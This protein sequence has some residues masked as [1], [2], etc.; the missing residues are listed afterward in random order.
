[1]AD[2]AMSS[3]L[4][5]S[6]WGSWRSGY[7]VYSYA[8]EVLDPQTLDELLTDREESRAENR[9]LCAACGHPI[10]RTSWRIVVGGAHQHRFTNPYGRVFHIGC[11]AEAPG[12]TQ[13][14][15]PTEEATWYNGFRW[16]IALCGNC[17]THVGWGFQEGSETAFFGLILDRLISPS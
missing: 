6:Q 7:R 8:F 17:Q 2:R 15:E 5:F 11:F 10:T 12:C 13:I 16:R 9:L 3:A 14:G 1:M 4:Q